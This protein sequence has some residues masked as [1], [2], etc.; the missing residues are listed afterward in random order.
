[1]RRFYHNGQ[2]LS[3]F[4]QAKSKII[5]FIFYFIFHNNVFVRQTSVF[6]LQTSRRRG[7]RKRGSPRFQFGRLAK[8]KR[9]FARRQVQFPASPDRQLRR[10]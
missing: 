9:K 1:M 8:P 4:F 2:K 5:N 10:A 7:E 6:C 3:N